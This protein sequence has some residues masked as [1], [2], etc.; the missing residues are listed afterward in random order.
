[1]RLIDADKL[2]DELFWTRMPSSIFE[3]NA[4]NLVT[5]NRQDEVEAIPVE[6]I[7]E[8]I[9]YQDSEEKKVL[10]MMWHAW[11]LRKKERC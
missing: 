5:I 8:Y 2:E 3:L 4:A 7:E 6:F 9:E 1:M 11:E 10:R